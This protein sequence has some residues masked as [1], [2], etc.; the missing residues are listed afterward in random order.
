MCGGGG[1]VC[2]C[3][4]IG[5]NLKIVVPWERAGDQNALKNSESK[6]NIFCHFE[7]SQCH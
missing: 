6:H 2:A 1:C 5:F 4:Q 7:M 3:Y